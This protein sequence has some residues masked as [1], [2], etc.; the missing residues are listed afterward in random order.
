MIINTLVVS[1]ITI[2][3]NPIKVSFLA[4]II[5]ILDPENSALTIFAHIDA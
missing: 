5:F 2:P 1:F 3:S 4:L